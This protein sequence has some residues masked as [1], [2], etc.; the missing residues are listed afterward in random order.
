[1]A[2]RSGLFTGGLAALKPP[3][4][5][6]AVFPQGPEVLGISLGPI[7]VGGPGV[8]PAGFIGGTN[9]QSEW[10]IYWAL[11]K[12]LGPEGYIWSYQQSF[13]GGRHLP[14]GAV[15]DFVVYYELYAVGM[16]IQTYFFHE[17]SLMGSYK[18]ASDLEQ[19]IS[20]TD[21]GLIVVDIY[22]QN[23]IHD[24]TGKAAIQQVLRAMQLVEEFNP[25]ATGT[26]RP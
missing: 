10:Y 19:R 23:F 15:V 13:L 4:P 2:K 7:Q 17:A 5:P 12:I 14:G 26:V 20:L 18:H 1:M 24:A 25:R 9:S 16:R 6:R 21:N 11:T 22:E 3:K 8:A